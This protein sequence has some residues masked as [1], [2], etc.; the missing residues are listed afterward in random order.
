[1]LLC[2]ADG[3]PRRIDPRRLPE[4]RLVP[5]ERVGMGDSRVL[6]GDCYLAHRALLAG[7]WAGRFKLAYLDPPFNTGRR[8]EHYDD[9]L[10]IGDWL[11]LMRDRLV[12]VR[13]LLA[14][15]GLLVVHLD[16]HRVHHARLLLDELFGVANFRNSLVIKRVYKNLGRQFERVQALPLAHDVCLLY[17]RN[18]ATRWPLPELPKPD[19]PRH[20]EGYW[21]D[22]WSTA[23][24]PTMR[25]ELLGV[26][27]LRG[28]WK[29]CRERAEQAVQNH[30]RYLAE[31]NGEPLV[32]WWRRHGARLEFIRLSESGRVVHWVPPLATQCADTLWCDIRGYSFRHRFPTEKSESLLERLLLFFSQPGDW[33]LDSFAGSGTTG[34]AATRL[35]RRFVLIEL[36]DQA[37]TRIVPR[38][39]AAGAEFGVDQVL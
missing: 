35:G 10:A 32:A 26:Q 24:R 18:P 33:V 3:E 15:D 8:F 23:D 14:D 30:R 7:G 20:P 5:L 11:C 17:S 6:W 34:A 19:G 38:L 4:P 13:E 29:W 16:D 27:P 39:R 2:D 12:Q 21:K 1:M 25:Y 22:F 9:D 28:Q 36:G 31:A 37:R